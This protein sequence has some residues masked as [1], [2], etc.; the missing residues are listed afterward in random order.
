LGGPNRWS[1]VCRSVCPGKL[2]SNTNFN[3]RPVLAARP[4]RGAAKNPGRPTH[5][6]PMPLRARGWKFSQG[7]PADTDE[8][9]PACNWAL[10]APRRK[11]AARPM[12]EFRAQENFSKKQRTTGS[13]AITAVSEPSKGAEVNPRRRIKSEGMVH[14]TEPGIGWK[15]SFAE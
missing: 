7:R 14:E 9:L 12:P 13:I 3:D 1:P 8:G 5:T 10:F 15:D 4:Q 11:R 2:I 6:G